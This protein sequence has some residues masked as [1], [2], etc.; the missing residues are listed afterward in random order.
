MLILPRQG[1][2]IENISG[3]ATYRDNSIPTGKLKKRSSNMASKRKLKGKWYIRV[4]YNGK[5]KLIPTYTSIE[6][7]ANILLRQFKLN[8][9]EVK[10]G[11][12][13]HLLYQKL[14]IED[15][16]K[17]FKRNYKTEKGI[18][19]STMDSYNVA[20]NDFE[21]CFSYTNNFYDIVKSD[22]PALV[23]YLSLRYNKTTVNIRLRGI[24]AFLNYLNEKDFIK[25]TPF[26]VKQIKLDK[27]FHKFIKPDELKKLYNAVDI[28]Q[29]LSCFRVFEITGM[30]RSEL[31][32][33]YRDGEFI[34]IIKSKV[35]AE[36]I[37]PIPANYINDYDIAIQAG[38]SPV[39]LSK[40]FT[41]YAIK[42]KLQGKTLHSLRHT[43][44]YKKLLETN[45]IQCVKELLG[46]STV[47]TTEIYTKMPMEYLFQVFV[48]DKQEGINIHAKT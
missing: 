48:N 5:E 43:F 20:L 9:Q 10:L 16:I 45:N 23:T 31:S 36:R 35:R 11:L 28:P 19:Q 6:R 12:S 42:A 33:S 21:N 24:R 38:Y 32:N 13:E 30:R 7:D 2:L 37:I 18:E 15:C 44:A 40:A 17:Y 46:H 47:T 34:H 14:T 39:W 3:Y 29:L 22:Y 25:E 4:R 8:E 26:N 1:Y 41:K 27:S